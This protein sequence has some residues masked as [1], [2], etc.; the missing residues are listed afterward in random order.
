MYEIP[1]DFW[2]FVLGS[3]RA[4]L[5]LHLAKCMGHGWHMAMNRHMGVSYL[6]WYSTDIWCQNQIFKTLDS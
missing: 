3:L 2:H 5:A 6:I 4:M 1:P